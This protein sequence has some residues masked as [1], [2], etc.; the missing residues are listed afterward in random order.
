M[1]IQKLSYLLL[2][3]VYL[4]IPVVLSAQKKVRFVFQLRYLLPAIVFSGAVFVMWNM[5]FVEIG[6]WSFNSD[7]LTG[8]EFLKV[9]IEEWLSL[10]IIPLS[11]VYIYEWLKIRLE[12]FEHANE[13]VIVSLVLFVIAGLLAYFFRQ[14]I[15]TFFTFFLTAIYLG[16]TV[17]R[18]RFKKHYTKFYL[19]FAIVLVPFII[20]SAAINAMPVIIYNADHIIGFGILGVPIEKLGYLFLLLLINVTIYEY[21][22]ARKY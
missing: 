9:P 4:V 7:Y 20:V 11:S 19:T 16:Y 12:S 13:F 2:L 10:L 14:N 22:S 6:I 17:F 5:R 1:E 8:I 15:F 3:L 18:N 21:L